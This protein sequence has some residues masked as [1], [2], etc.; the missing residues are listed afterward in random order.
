MQIP[1][2][3]AQ[4]VGGDATLTEIAKDLRQIGN[5]LSTFEL[6]PVR[7]NDLSVRGIRWR[8]Q[9]I[10]NANV[11]RGAELFGHTIL[12]VNER[13]IIAAHLLGRALH[14]TVAAVIFAR[15]KVETLIAGHDAAGLA[16]A[17][18]RLT[19]GSRYR[20]TSTGGESPQPYNVLSMIDEASSQFDSL[21]PEDRWHQRGEF[22]AHYDLLSEFAHPSM[23]SFSAYQKVG[24][25]QNIFDRGL[26]IDWRPHS[27]L[28]AVRLSARFLVD[29]A[30]A[31]GSIEDL[32]PEWPK[33]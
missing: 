13:S 30:L 24:E 12:A 8:C 11:L 18:N 27:V 21:L 16:R 9:G 5:E 32:P 23:G 1:D 3:S 20:H 25:A 17:L 22:R 26:G 4:L 7:R 28:S 14:E 10:A 33:R 6:F 2:V 19:V 15:R 31:Q 29:E